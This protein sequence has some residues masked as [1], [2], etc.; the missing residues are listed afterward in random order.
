MYDQFSIP[1]PV[2]GNWVRDAYP[3]DLQ[4]RRLSAKY[5]QLSDE[6]LRETRR[7]YYGQISY[8]DYQLGRFLGEL[9]TRGLYEDTVIVFNSDHGEHLGDH[10]VFG[11]TTFLS[12]SGDMPMLMRFPH[13]VP[14]A[15]PALEVDAPVLTVDLFPTVL[16]LAGLEPQEHCDGRSLLPALETGRP[17][18]VG[19]VI[20]GEY[21]R[22]DGTAFAMD[23]RYKYVYYAKGGI[24]HLFDVQADP[25]NLEN[26][27]RYA[28]YGP[29]KNKLKSA[30]VAYLEQFDRPLVRDGRL[31]SLD[32]AMDEFAWRGRNPCAWRGP[33]RY[34]QGY[35][36]GW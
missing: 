26:L 5:D 12:G 4:A 28:G 6:A 34:G 18:P 30:L 16:E 23:R 15:H 31:I 1:K 21:G 10:G 29:V 22:G 3:P 19:R 20:C 8:I 32:V 11:K 35:G 13:W 24:E 17:D 27:A 25:A 36:G 7:R 14:L 33:M 9:K 2:Y